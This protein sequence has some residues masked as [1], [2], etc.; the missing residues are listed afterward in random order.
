MNKKK[1]KNCIQI[2]QIKNRS[3]I[4]NLMNTKLKNK[5]NKEKNYSNNLKS[6]KD[7]WSNEKS[8]K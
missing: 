8:N 3:K 1:S 4:K 7:K 2:I 5:N 6:K